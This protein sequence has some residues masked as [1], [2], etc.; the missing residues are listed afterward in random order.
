MGSE[1]VTLELDDNELSILQEALYTLREEHR[2]EGDQ[3]ALL[4]KVLKA[5]GASEEF[6]SKVYA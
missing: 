3:H 4:L 1:T 6:L 2:L 5:R